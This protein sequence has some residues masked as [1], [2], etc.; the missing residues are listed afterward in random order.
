MYYYSYVMTTSVTISVDIIDDTSD[1][2]EEEFTFTLLDAP[3]GVSFNP[4]VATVTIVDNDAAVDPDPVVV[5]FDSATY[6]VNE[7]SGTVEL[8]VSVIS[9]VLT[10][11]IK[12]SYAVSDVSTTVSDDYT[13]TVAMLELSLMTTSVTISVDIIDDTSDEPEEEFTF[14]LLDAP[15]GVSFN[16]TVATVT[17]VDNDE[18]PAPV[19]VEIGFDFAT[20]RVNEGSGTVELTVSVLSGVLT[21]TLR[22]SYAVSDVSTTVSDDYTVTVNMLEL[23]LMT[24]SVTI[25]VDIIDDTSDEP[26]EEFTFT[27]LDAPVGISFN[28]TV[29]T[30]TIVDND[31]APA[32]VDVEIGFDSATYRVNEGSGT[33]E[34]TVSVLSG[35][36]TETIRL[37]YA[38]SDVS[39]TV[40]DDY[41]VTVAM[42][43]LSLMTTSVTISVD[44][45]DDTSDEP[46][47][48]FTFTLLDAPVG[49]SFNPTV[50]TVTIVDNDEAPKPVVVGFDSAT[51]RVNEGSGTVELTVSVLSGVLTEAIRLSYAVSDVSTTVSD[52]YTVTVAMLELSLMTSSVTISVDII[53]DTSDEPEEEFTFTLLDA[54]VGISF[55]PTVATVTIVDNDEAPEP[56]GIE[57]GFDSATYRVNEGSGTVELTVSVLSGVLMETITLSYAVSDVSTTVSDDYTVTVAMLELSLMTTSVTIIVDI[58]DDTSDEPEEEFTFTLL[59][60]PVGISFNPTRATV[61][62]VDNDAAVDPDPVVVG[63]DSATYRVNEGS[64]TVELT[65]SVLSGVLTE[66]LRLSYAVSD[67]STT[68][69][70]DYTVTVAMLELSLM[71]TSVTISVDIIDD[72]SDEPE[73]EFTVTLLDA[74]VGISFN[75]TATTVTIVD[76]DEAPGPV[77]V[78]FD[79][80]T[81]RVNEGSGTVELTVSVLSGVLTETLRLNYAVSDVSTMVS[82]D[83]TVTVNMLELSLMT[84][85]VTII[86]DIIDD[87]SLESEEEF[88]FTLLDAPV[89]VSFNPTAATVTIVDND[90]APKPVVVGFDSATY[91]VNEG[92]G[93]VELTVSVLSGVL[94]ETLRLNYAVSDVSTTV[95]DD[96]TVTVA[97]LELSLM[98]TSVTIIVDIIDDT[99]LESEEEFTFTLL[100]APVGVSFNP[101]AA[102]VTIVDNDEAPGPVVVGFDSATYRVNEGSGTVE[103]TVSVLSGVL[104]ETLRLNYAVSDVSTTVSDDYTVTVNMLELSLMTSSVTIIVDIIDDTSL[105]SEEEFTFTLLDAPVGISFNPTATTVTIVDNDEAPGPVVVGFDSATYRVNEGSGT[106]ELTVSVLS[107]VLTETLRLNYAVSDVSTMV[108]DDYTV[109]VNMLELSL[110]TTSVTIIVDIIDDTSLESEEEFTFTLLDAPVGVSFNP[111][112]ATVTIVDNDEAPKPVVVGFDSATYRVN[113]GSGTVELTVSVLSGVLTET[114]RLNYAVSDV[115]TTVSDDYTVTVNMLEL[116]LMTS[117]VTIIVDI[118]DDTSLESEEEF[119]FTLL[120]APV[121]ISFNPTAT[122]VTIVDNDEAPGLWW[123]DLTPRRIV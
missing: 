67:V 78:G 37:S 95:S 115:S 119:T 43:E 121:G 55:N 13:V 91:R 33:V 94:T 17:I 8:T 29:A 68:V 86:V 41:T 63:F 25:I 101:T 96:Y 81:Y 113:E 88:T 66:T 16:P 90:E 19:D 14:T 35:V 93:T 9:G 75:P 21:E 52:D 83:Y 6:R 23:S 71:T 108:S 20:Y 36:L 103:L 2:P 64:G 1:E 4:T 51:Y 112:A 70:D 54:P 65:V 53:D 50:A 46:E 80:A 10:E 79:S 85:S 114:L 26:E 120:D 99:S 92:S 7:G 49:V 38:V 31:E 77:V 3:V 18:A 100:D 42:L 40:S 102:T 110:M 12:L 106:V 69:S 76:N 22:L 34:L 30:V 116:S 89:G 72:T 105:E 107:G 74:P 97:M 117:S 122:T 39:T 5:G 104:T 56:V 84:T 123:L 60:A 98:T 32:P 15:V 58:I 47:E 48:E 82:D 24:S 28:P 111:T 61:T 44:I 62:I 73:E 57:I 59:D 87:T 27:L 11:A 45:I 109:T 118:I